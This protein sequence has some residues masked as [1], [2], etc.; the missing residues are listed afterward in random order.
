RKDDPEAYVRTVIVREHI[1][2]WRRLSSR[3]RVIGVHAE[4]AR[5]DPSLAAVEDRDRLW[6]ALTSL[7]ARQRAIVVLRHLYDQSE[8]QTA[9]QMRCSVGTVKSQCSRGLQ[10]LRAA[11]SGDATGAD[12]E[13]TDAK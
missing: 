9:E 6:T 3:E 7:P 13:P 4:V 11:L 10:R 2:L 5:L 1:N 8:Q 12:R